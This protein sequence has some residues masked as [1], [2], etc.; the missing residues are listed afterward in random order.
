MRLFIGL[1]LPGA[2]K[3]QIRATQHG[4]R[5]ARWQNSNQLHLTLNFIGQVPEDQAPALCEL[6]SAFQFAPFSLQ[7]TGAGR[8]GTRALWLGVSPDEPVIQLHE[9]FKALLAEQDWPTE[10]RRFRPHV[11][12]ARLGRRSDCTDYLQTHQD[13]RS[14]P[15]TVRQAVLFSSAQGPQGSHYEVIA[16]TAKPPRY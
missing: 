10:N 11:T 2:I 9:S 8:F 5:H 7:L 14:P 6:V 4:I 12:V 3:R 16:R 15:F 1:T 13:F